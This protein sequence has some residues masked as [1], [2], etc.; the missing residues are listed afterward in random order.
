MYNDDSGK[1]VKNNIEKTTGIKYIIQ[2]IFDAFK[3]AD[4]LKLGEFNFII[5]RR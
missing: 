3:D 1:N 4:N 2:G 5:N